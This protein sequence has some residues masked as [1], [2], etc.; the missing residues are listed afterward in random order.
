MDG[1]RPFSVVPSDRMRSDGHKLKV[2]PQHEEELCVEGDRALEQGAQGR[3][4]VF[5]SGDIQNPP[6][7]FHNVQVIRISF[8]TS[9]HTCSDLCV[10]TYMHV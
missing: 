7:A 8:L 4:G 6:D 9:S 2:P 1:A 3:A 5:L 10:L